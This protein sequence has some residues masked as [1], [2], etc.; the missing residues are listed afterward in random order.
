MEIDERDLMNLCRHAFLIGF[1]F[2][3]GRAPIH[4]DDEKDLFDEAERDVYLK[5]NMDE[6]KFA[7]HMSYGCDQ[8]SLGHCPPD[9]KGFT[10]DND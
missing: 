2:G 7:G 6:Y 3:V 1:N 10:D 5:M 4:I 9:C 8:G